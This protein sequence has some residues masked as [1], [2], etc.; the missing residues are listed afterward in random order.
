[1]GYYA[2][3]NGADILILKKDHDAIMQQGQRIFR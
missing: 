1:M 3:S 2:H